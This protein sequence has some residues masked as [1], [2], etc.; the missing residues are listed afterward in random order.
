MKPTRRVAS[1]FTLIEVLVVLVITSLITTM[2]FQALSQ[3]FRIQSS[4]A[5][6]TLRNTD[7]ALRENWFRLIGQGLYPDA[8]L[9]PDEF[10]GEERNL[11]GLTLFPLNA[12]PGAPTP[13]SLTIE[14]AGAA[15]RSSVIYKSGDKSMTLASWQGR[16]GRFW[17]EDE[18]GLRYEQWP[19]PLGM[20]T[21]LPNVVL[22]QMQDDHLPRLLPASPLGR[23]DPPLKASDVFKSDFQ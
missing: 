23:R 9:G 4:L 16:S 7:V 22:L 12:P 11:H 10:K 14:Y 6:Q 19:P 15:D 2:L 3:M 18:A 21:E 5:A 13:F 8:R 17:Y 1:G 20:S